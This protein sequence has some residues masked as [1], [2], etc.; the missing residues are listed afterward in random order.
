MIIHTSTCHWWNQTG[1]KPRL[2]RLD[3]NPIAVEAFEASTRTRLGNGLA[4][5]GLQWARKIREKALGY[6]FSLCK[7]QPAREAV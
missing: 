6:K 2:V 3:Q 5:L 7:R 4:R 1:Y